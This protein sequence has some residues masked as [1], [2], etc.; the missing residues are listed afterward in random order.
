MPENFV[1]KEVNGAARG[2]RT[3]DIQNH[4]LAF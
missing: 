3:L 1:G 4:N 2:N